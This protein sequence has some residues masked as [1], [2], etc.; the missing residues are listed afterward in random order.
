MAVQGDIFRGVLSFSH[1]EGSVMQLVFTWEL[2]DSDES[3]A[4]CLSAIDDWVDND[5]VPA[6]E[7][8]AIDEVILYLMEVDVLNGDGT[9]DRN[10]GDELHA[11]PGVLADEAMPSGVAGFIQFG[12][13]RAK[14]VGRKYVP[15]ISEAGSLDGRFTAAVLGQLVAILMATLLDIPVPVAGVLVPGVL[16]RVTELFLEADGSGYATEVPA[17]QRR[18]KLHVGS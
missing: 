2:Q 6:W 15:G 8:R 14:S 11:D 13:E 5:F 18:R 4:A 7:T 12:T 17:Y 9:V 1:P 3:D 16:S 10:I